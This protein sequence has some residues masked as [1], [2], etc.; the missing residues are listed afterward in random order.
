[1]NLESFRR[2][3]LSFPLATEDI[4]W[5]NDLLFRINGKIFA[6][7]DLSSVPNSIMFKCAPERFADLL[8]IEGVEPAPYVGRFKWV[9]VHSLS[10][11]PAS[12][13]QDLV[14]QSYELISRKAGP[15]KRSR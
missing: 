8:E 2:F 15:P 12:E 10:T 9:K 4:Q 14:R 11:L 6:G 5:E 1:V 3:C 7:V 13:I